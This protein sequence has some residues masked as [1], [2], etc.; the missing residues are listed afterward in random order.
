LLTRL[1]KVFVCI[2]L[3]RLYTYMESGFRCLYVY[4]NLFAGWHCTT[5]PIGRASVGG[6]HVDRGRH[7]FVDPVR[8]VDDGD[9]GCYSR[10][11][12]P[13]GAFCRRF[14]KR[15]TRSKS[16]A[17]TPLKLRSLSAERSGKTITTSLKFAPALDPKLNQR[18]SKNGGSRSLSAERNTSDDK[19][20]VNLGAESCDM[21]CV[22]PA[23]AS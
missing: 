11:H 19:E 9:F 7:L 1:C 15:E 21:D 13:C 5:C 2:H 17:F 20:C 12:L 6:D 23:F 14:P 18:R 8:E 22:K 16:V 4:I 3:C 10:Y